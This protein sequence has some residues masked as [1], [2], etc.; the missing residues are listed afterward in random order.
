MPATFFPLIVTSFGHFSSGLIFNVFS[1]ASARAKDD[2]IGK[3]V[4][5]EISNFG[6]RIIDSQIPPIGDD[7]FLPCLPLPE[8][9]LWAIITEPFSFWFEAIVNA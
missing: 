2:A 4:V 9:C 5:Y 6:W 3:S 8:V 7:H 1:I